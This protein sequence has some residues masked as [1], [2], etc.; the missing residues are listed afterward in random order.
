MTSRADP[1]SPS[2]YPLQWQTADIY[3]CLAPCNECTENYVSE[4]L[5]KRFVCHWDVIIQET[6]TLALQH[7]ALRR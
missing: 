6:V 5:E 7:Y 2:P 4:L 3:M 1:S